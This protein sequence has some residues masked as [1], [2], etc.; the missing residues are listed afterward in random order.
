[1]G[2]LD[3]IFKPKGEQSEMSEQA[4]LATSKDRWDVDL[5]D[6]K[7]VHEKLIE[8]QNKTGE[9]SDLSNIWQNFQNKKEGEL[10]SEQDIDKAFEGAK[11]EELERH[12]VSESEEEAKEE[13]ASDVWAESRVDAYLAKNLSLQDMTQVS[14]IKGEMMDLVKK[15]LKGKD[16]KEWATIFENLKAELDSLNPEAEF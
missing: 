10:P 3:K 11:A 2:F 4:M 6:S 8:L 12:K 14:K 15:E 1:M 13:Q 7:A 16:S 9:V 5:N